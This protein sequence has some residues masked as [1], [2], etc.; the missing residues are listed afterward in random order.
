MSR[1]K[2][3]VFIIFVL[4][5]IIILAAICLREF[6]AKYVSKDKLQSNV[7]ISLLL[8]GDE[9]DMYESPAALT[10]SGAYK[11]RAERDLEEGEP[12]SNLVVRENLYDYVLPGVNIPKDPKVFITKKS[13]ADAYLYIEVIED[14]FPKY[15]THNGF[16]D[17]SVDTNN[18][19]EISPI[20]YELEEIW[21]P[22]L[23]NAGNHVEGLNGGKLYVY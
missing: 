6:N 14:N 11:L 16:A 22:V 18:P 8:Q 17:L 19:T 23:D 10:S 7:Q 4:S 15:Y 5:I 3:K 20:Y 13:G 2:S 12:T 21:T 1:R 9:A